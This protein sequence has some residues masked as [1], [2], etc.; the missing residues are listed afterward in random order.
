MKNFF[1]EFKKFMMRG[2]VMDMAIGVVMGGAFTAIINAVVNSLL[3]PCIAA[4]IGDINF[5]DLAV[6]L[7]PGT[8]GSDPILL[9]YGVII[10]EIIEFVLIAFF[11][12]LIVRML[13]RLREIEAEK[14][15]AEE[16]AAAAAAAPAEPA[17][18]VIPEDIKLLTEIRDLLKKEEAAK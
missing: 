7:K 11:L 5:T 10:Q 4:L 6:T 18:P 2:S 9:S 13:N 17:E 12:F 3:M 8:E 1:Q 16:A 14:K 15:A